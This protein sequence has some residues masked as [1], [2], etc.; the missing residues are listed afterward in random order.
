MTDKAVNKRKQSTGN[1]TFC[2]LPTKYLLSKYCASVCEK[3]NRQMHSTIHC[4]GT[5]QSHLTGL[6]YCEPY[7]L[8]HPPTSPKIAMVTKALLII[9][10]SAAVPGCNSDMLKVGSQLDCSIVFQG[11]KR[12][13]MIAAHSFIQGS[14]R[15]VSQRCRDSAPPA[16]QFTGKAFITSIL[17]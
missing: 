16:T 1:S 12:K 13:H 6:G 15:H 2:F 4:L 11:Q 8:P 3:E 5:L 10:W 17:I 7:I 14:C 9:S